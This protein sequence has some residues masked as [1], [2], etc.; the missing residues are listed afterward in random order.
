MKIYA[1]ALALVATT[2]SA[3]P[4]ELFKSDRGSTSWVMYPETFSKIE[5]GYAAMI[6]KRAVNNSKPEVRVFMGVDY[7]TCSKGFGSLYTK[8]SIQDKW[9]VVSNVSTKSLATNADAIATAICEV[10]DEVE[11]LI[12]K[13]VD[14]RKRISV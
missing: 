1:I 8:E 3:E 4:I 9:K 10:G 5:D 13:P 12:K 11:K 7:E 6:G 2:A 14:T